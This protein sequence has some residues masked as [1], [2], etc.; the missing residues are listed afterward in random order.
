M[1]RGSPT[2][3]GTWERVGYLAVASEFIIVNGW[4]G[5]VVLVGGGG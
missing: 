2:H 3:F 5:W 1:G 4:E